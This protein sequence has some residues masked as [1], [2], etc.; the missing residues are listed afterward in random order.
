[1]PRE[2][3]REKDDLLRAKGFPLTQSGS[4]F[5][6]NLLTDNQEQYYEN[7]DY[8]G[9]NVQGFNRAGIHRNRSDRDDDGYD[10]RGFLANGTHRNG[11]QYDGDGLDVTG[12]I[13][14]EVEELQIGKACYI[15]GPDDF[16]GRDNQRDLTEG[17]EKLSVHLDDRSTR[18]H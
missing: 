17:P 3:P 16:L 2:M 1:M 8:Q 18:N 9:F 15:P 10:I 4:R 6:S 5:G 12:L 11:R 7:Y 14:P 13:H